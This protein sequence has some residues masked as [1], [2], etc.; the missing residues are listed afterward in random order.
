ARTLEIF[1]FAAVT[2]LIIPQRHGAVPRGWR[3]A[4]S[5]LCRGLAARAPEEVP[6]FH[7]AVADLLAADVAGLTGTPVDVDLAPVVVLA[8]SPAHHL[9]GVLGADGIDPSA[10][11]T[12]GH[13]FHEVLPHALAFLRRQVAGAAVRVDAQAEQGFS[14]IDVS[15]PGVA[16]LVHEDR[17]DASAGAGEELIE[18]REFRGVFRVN[19][20]VGGAQRVGAELGDRGIHLLVGD[21]AAPL[22]SA[23]IRLHRIAPGAHIL[24]TLGVDAVQ[25]Q[26]H[27][28]AGLA[29]GEGLDG[30]GADQTQ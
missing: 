6:A 2:P 8:G 25:V 26:A 27:L 10:G 18:L 4:V 7:H 14:P 29:P 22:G 20:R 11:L 13:E 21:E 16:S 19:L 30:Q 28:T 17:T 9:R 15:H 1:F 3:P 5:R 24:P 23:Q 12:L